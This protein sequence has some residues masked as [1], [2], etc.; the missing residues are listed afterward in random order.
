VP[1][2]VVE[3]GWMDYFIVRDPDGHEIVFA[4]TDPE[5]HPKDPW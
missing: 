3:T 5:R 2:A 4:V 1:G